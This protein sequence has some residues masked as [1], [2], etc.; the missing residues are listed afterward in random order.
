MKPLTT[1]ATAAA[2][3][4][5]LASASH[6]SVFISFDGST[7]L[8][9][10]PDGLYSFAA[11]CVPTSLC[12]GFKDISITG[13]TGDLPSL[14]HSADVSAT[15][16]STVDNSASETIYVTRTDLN[17]PHFNS[18]GSSFT[19]NNSPASGP[20]PF[21]VSLS[22]YVSSTN[23]LYSGALLSSFTSSAPGATSFNSTDPGFSGGGLWS[24]TEKYVIT[25]TKVSGK[26]NSA[27]PSIVLDGV[28]VPEPAT[29]AMM[30]MG[31]GGV[32]AVMRQRRRSVATA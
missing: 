8:F 27:S 18:F 25:A 29:W 7:T 9:S 30:I 3:A 28:G 32:G 21:T 4:L 5:G 2:L 26:T 12:G 11:T 14:L 13:Q 23:S 6:A 24:V 22:T 20:T 10:A 1:F 17:G 31:L 19:S 16:K 15:T